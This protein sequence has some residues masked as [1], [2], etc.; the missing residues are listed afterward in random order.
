VVDAVHGCTKD[1]A[2]CHWHKWAKHSCRDVSQ[3]THITNHPIDYR[4]AGEACVVAMSG[5][6][7]SA[8]ALAERSTCGPAVK[9]SVE[10]SGTGAGSVVCVEQMGYG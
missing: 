4:N 6:G 3:E 5:Q 2:K 10:S 8:P 1:V 9:V 7:F